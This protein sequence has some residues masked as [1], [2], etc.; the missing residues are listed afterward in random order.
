MQLT[1]FAVFD[2]Q[3]GAYLQPFFMRAQGEALRAFTASVN[4]PSTG[5]FKNPEDYSLCELGSFDDNTGV[6]TAHAP[7][8]VAQAA[9]V[10]RVKKLPLEEHIERLS[11]R[12]RFEQEA[13]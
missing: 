1:M 2:R 8:C 12:D 4:D 11:T 9:S 10:I 6:M 5:F 3:V 13:G 7:V